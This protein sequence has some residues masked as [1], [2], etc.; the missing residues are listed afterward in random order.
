MAAPEGGMP[1]SPKAP[2]KRMTTARRIREA[3]ASYEHKA[4]LEN[5]L[6][7]DTPSAVLS[8]LRMKPPWQPTSRS[9]RTASEVSGPAP[10][11]QVFG[12]FL[13]FGG[14]EIESR[15]W[16]G[17]VLMVMH[18]AVCD[19]APIL[20]IQDEGA[21]SS[22]PCSHL[23]HFRGWNFWRFELKF[24]LGREARDVAYTVSWGDAAGGSGGRV[25]GEG[26]RKTKGHVFSLPNDTQTWRWGFH[27]CNGFDDLEEVGVGEEWGGIQP[28]WQ[29]VMLRHTQRPIHV[30]VGGG[31]QLYN[32]QV[33][34]LPSMLEY[35]SV[36]EKKQRRALPFTQEQSDEVSQFYMDAY[37]KHWAQPLF[38]DA[39][40]SIPQLM[41]W[42]DHD[43]FDGWG[44][45]PDELQSCGVFQGIF[46]WAKQFYCLFQQHATPETIAASN[47]VFGGDSWNCVTAFG[48]SLAVVV[49]DSRSQRTRAHCCTDE[50]YCLL[51]KRLALL[52]STIQHVA[53]IAGVPLIYPHIPGAETC[54]HAISSKTC[55]GRS[56]R[57][58]LGK[59][60]V[61]DNL[62]NAFGEIEILDDLVDH[63]S[64]PVRVAEKRQLLA[65]V[66][67][68]ALKRSLRFTFVSGDVHVAGFGKFLSKH[69]PKGGP[70]KDH[71]Y[72][73]QIISSA[74]GNNPPP[75]NVVRALQLF[76]SKHK[77]TNDTAEKMVHL[78]PGHILKNQRNWALVEQR[79][80]ESE[81]IINDGS[82]IFQIRLEDRSKLEAGLKKVTDK[83][84]SFMRSMRAEVPTKIKVKANNLV[85]V[86]L[87]IKHEEFDPDSLTP[88]AQLSRLSS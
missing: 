18:Q 27:S 88:W 30:M 15:Q 70:K 33:W 14:Y 80:F 43:I 61:L 22:T 77:V 23:H 51:Q 17:S 45:Y 53:V 78:A 25:G 5:D 86:P 73:P 74:I 50:S 24:T 9:M 68:I 56:S 3:A 46:H 48:P 4:S 31:D 7:N 21:D 12:P 84:G 57:Y 47:G 1:M 66:Q 59:T 67:E 6:R 83:A 13:R 72:M 44:S 2:L 37:A 87:I 10:K 42:D 75:F 36:P 62:N 65:M 29:D 60:G 26:V 71:R 40:A 81:S 63:W 28:L 8:Q 58:V 52:P 82:L 34:E 54:I 32:D 85:V 55:F 19:A 11:Q 20:E 69:E 41:T 38:S 49:L 76:A 64:S 35:L 16:D 79:P 39:L